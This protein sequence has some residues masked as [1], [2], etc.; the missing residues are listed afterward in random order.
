[1]MELDLN[2]GETL[3]CTCQTDSRKHFW[4]LEQVDS[5]SD[6]MENTIENT[7]HI[8]WQASIEHCLKIM[9][10]LDCSY[11]KLR[12]NTLLHIS[13][14]FLEAFLKFKTS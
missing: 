13:K 11:L 14:I 9:M 10:E 8:V 1:M 5:D 4:N 12:D 2:W 6:I 3:Y 7:F